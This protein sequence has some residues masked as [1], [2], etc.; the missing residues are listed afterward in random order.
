MTHWRISIGG[1]HREFDAKITEQHPD[2]RVAWSSADGTN[3]SGV[4][5]FHRLDADNTRFT[6][7]MVTSPRAS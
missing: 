1:V 3:H 7:Q 4:D 5:T 6:L 2:E